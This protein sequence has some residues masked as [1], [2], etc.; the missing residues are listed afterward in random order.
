M[1]PLLGNVCGLYSSSA[2][3]LEANPTQVIAAV[4]AIVRLTRPKRLFMKI[5]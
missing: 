5:V 3:A 2:R 1:L 4:A